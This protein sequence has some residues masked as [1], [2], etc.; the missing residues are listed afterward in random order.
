M[1]KTTNQLLYIAWKYKAS[2]GT[3]E[4]HFGHVHGELQPA[5]AKAESGEGT[6]RLWAIFQQEPNFDGLKIIN[7]FLH[8]FLE[9]GLPVGKIF[10]S[11]VH[12]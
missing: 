10:D 1:F 9:T 8:F 3:R 5:C 4:T 2:Q 7:G 6:D 12:L 11:V